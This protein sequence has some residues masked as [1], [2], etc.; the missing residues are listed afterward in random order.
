MASLQ[1]VIQTSYYSVDAKAP[2]TIVIVIPYL[3]GQTID[4]ILQHPDIKTH[5]HHINGALSVS[6]FGQPVANT[7]LPA[8]EDRIELCL[9]LIQDPKERRRQKIKSAPSAT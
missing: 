8:P 9:P 2:H 3:V 4:E 5:T 1:V 7:H 6:I